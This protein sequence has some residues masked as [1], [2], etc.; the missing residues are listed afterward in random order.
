MPD[1]LKEKQMIHMLAR[2]LKEV[3][4]SKDLNQHGLAQLVGCTQGLISHY[5]AG[6]TKITL[7]TLLD[8]ADALGCS[9]DYLIGREVA[10]DQSARGRLYRAF[11]HLTADKQEM[12]VVMLEAAAKENENF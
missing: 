11:E 7:G 1:S 3:R 10:Y 6:V 4:E 8:I 2:R 9:V 12:V 5:E